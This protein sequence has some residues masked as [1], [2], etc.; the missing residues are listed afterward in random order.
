MA[1]LR[2]WEGRKT[3]LT[4]GDMTY[5]GTIVSGRFPSD[6][7]S[8]PR[9]AAPMEIGYAFELHNRSLIRVYRKGYPRVIANDGGL[10]QV[11]RP[12]G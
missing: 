4:V 11:N 12:A 10:V 1:R 9:R 3:T 6:R 5:F 7:P 2:L 8:Y